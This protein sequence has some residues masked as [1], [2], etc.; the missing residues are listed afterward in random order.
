MTYKY[1]NKD[2]RVVNGKK[3]VR[4]VSVKNGRGYKS[5]TKYRGKKRLWTVKK[6]I[7]DD[8]I[9]LIG[10]GKFIPGLFDDCICTNSKKTKK[11]K[12]SKK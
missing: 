5:V 9:P 8:H 3:T 7:H 4:V 2:V 11:N 1:Y 12:K 6:P 10:G